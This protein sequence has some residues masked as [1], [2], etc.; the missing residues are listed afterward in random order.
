MF[1]PTLQQQPSNPEMESEDGN[2]MMDSVM[3]GETDEITQNLEQ[4][5][6]TLPPEYKDYLASTLTDP[7]MGPVVVNVLGIIAGKEVYD[8]FSQALASLQTPESEQPAPDMAAAPQ[9]QMGQ[10]VF[11]PQTKDTSASTG[12]FNPKM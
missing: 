6:N 3:E 9:E 8:F 11:Q 5:L 4:H 10:P 1:Q 2:E 7:A 12:V